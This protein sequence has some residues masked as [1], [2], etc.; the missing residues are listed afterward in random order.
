MQQTDIK[1]DILGHHLNAC[2]LRNSSSEGGA[3]VLV[4]LHEA[5]GSIELWR[6][7]PAILAQQTGCDIL[8]YERFGHGHSAPLPKAASG[9]DYMAYEA[10]QVL[11]ELLQ[12][13][14]VERPLLLGH[15]DGATLALMYAARFPQ[16]VAGVVSEAAHLFV[17]E[18]TLVGIRIAKRTCQETRLLERLSR[19]HIDPEPI[20]RRWTEIWLTPEFSEWSIEGLMAQITCPVLAIQGEEDEYGTRRQ[21][22]ALVEG[23]SGSAQALMIPNCQHIP[24]FQAQQVFL[25]AVA[26]F[27]A[28]NKW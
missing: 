27:V 12:K 21:V 28:A 14:G 22:E 11:P 6:E 13:C 9:A 18:L 16:Q 2:W 17:D 25:T 3:P 1:L 8:I 10:W 24:H 23:V 7:I 20:F 5:L 19:Y 15:S 26:D 4:L